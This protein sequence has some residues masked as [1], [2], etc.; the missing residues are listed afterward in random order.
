MRGFCLGARKRGLE[1]FFIKDGI[2]SRCRSKFPLTRRT[3]VFSQSRTGLVNSFTLR[4]FKLF[5]GLEAVTIVK[6]RRLEEV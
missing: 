2:P 3:V 1:F 4:A 6:I 5:G